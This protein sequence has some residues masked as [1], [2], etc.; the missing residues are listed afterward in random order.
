[1]RDFVGDTDEIRETKNAAP[2]TDEFDQSP[3][4]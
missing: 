2:I 1:V 4:A 3:G